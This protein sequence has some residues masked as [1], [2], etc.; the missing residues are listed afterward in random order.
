MK[1]MNFVSSEKLISSFFCFLP[2]VWLLWWGRLRKVYIF[3]IVKIFIK[4]YPF[5]LNFFF[6]RRGVINCSLRDGAILCMES[7][8]L[9]ETHSWKIACSSFN[10]LGI[11]A[12]FKL[13]VLSGGDI[14]D[15][16]YGRFSPQILVYLFII[17]F[18]E[19]IGT[20]VGLFVR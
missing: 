19:R 15:L 7:P 16:S 3:S 4:F 8:H 17:I 6:L 11:I 14:D 5:F 18:L 9:I 2:L 10:L 20:I 13:V 1:L 12:D